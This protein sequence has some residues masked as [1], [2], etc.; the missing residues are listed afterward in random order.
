M[1]LMQD[2]Q[3]QKYNVPEFKGHNQSQ[4]Q[5][6]LESG[7]T[8]LA[9]NMVTRDGTLT[10]T[11]G[12]SK[13]ITTGAPSGLRTLM[14]F[15]KNNSNGTVTKTL[16]AT[17][18]TNIYKWDGSTWVSIKSG[19]TNGYFSFIN[20]QQ[21]TTDIVIMGNGV[22]NT[23]KWDGTTFSD[24]KGD[25][26]NPATLAPKLSSISLHYERIWGTGNREYP[27]SAF[28]SAAFGP[29]N[30]MQLLD[31]GGRADFPTFDGGVCI[32]LST[33]FDDVVIFKTYNIWKV[34]GTYPGEYQYV[35]LFS[36]VGGIAKRTII[37]AGNIAFFLSQDGLY[38]YDGVK[39]IPVSQKVDTIIKTMNK[40]FRDKAVGI[41][42][43]NRYILAIPT[44]SSVENDT[45]IEFDLLNQNFNVKKG[46]NVTDFLVFDDKLLFI[47]NGLHVMEY[48]K[49]DTFDGVPIVAFWETPKTSLASPSTVKASTYL[50]ADLEFLTAGAQA[51]FI[52]QFDTKSATTTTSVNVPKGMRLKGKGRKFNLR[53]ENVSG[54][55]FKLRLP[56]LHFDVDSD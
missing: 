20:Y 4:D 5:F 15:Y 34:I 52:A 33:I 18:D 42:H 44:G 14:A 30:W 36:A 32:G 3:S 13:Y 16:L 48:D 8:A 6:Q 23:F 53:I 19:I 46:F 31:Q 26:D 38:I 54:S 12:N 2:E 9:Q 22:D 24:L 7:E 11:L 50:Y 21:G 51:R 25:P 35:K 29:E 41:F 47:N 28:R 49:G 27:N 55:R 10:V 1:A 43:D 40:G 17:S 39:T 45:I 37:D 56:E